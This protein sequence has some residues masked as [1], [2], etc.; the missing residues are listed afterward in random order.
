MKAK[1][2]TSLYNMYMYIS[3]TTEGEY[4]TQWD[5]GELHEYVEM[6]LYGEYSFIWDREESYAI[7]KFLKENFDFK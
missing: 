2:L 5:E 1:L 3:N 6:I 4:N 7:F